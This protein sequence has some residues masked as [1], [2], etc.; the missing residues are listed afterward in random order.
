MALASPSPLSDGTSR[1]LPCVGV[2]AAHG[3]STLLDT[4]FISPCRRAAATVSCSQPEPGR[5]RRCAWTLWEGFRG[6]GHWNGVLEVALREEESYDRINS[7]WLLLVWVQPEVSRKR[8]GAAGWRGHTRC[9]RLAW[10]CVRPQ[11]SWETERPWGPRDGT[12]CRG[13]EHT[14]P[15]GVSFLPCMDPLHSLLG[16]FPSLLPPP[17]PRFPVL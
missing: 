16:R 10:A 1:V 15:L 17:A 4:S 2:A 13:L 11:L 9:G 6:D 5:S 12:S 8:A 3:P 14:G 7:W